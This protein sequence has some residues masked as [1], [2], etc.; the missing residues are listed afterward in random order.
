MSYF[1][2]SAPAN[3]V[4]MMKDEYSLDSFVETG[5]YMGVTA[6]W[7]SIH[8]KDVYTIESLQEYY[9]KAQLRLINSRNMHMFF[10]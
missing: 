4:L 9:D 5:T 2:H 10:E 3:I 1:Y 6:E 7:A 8:F